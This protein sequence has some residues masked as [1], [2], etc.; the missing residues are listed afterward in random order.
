ME[1]GEAIRRRREELKLSQEYV[2]ERLGV[3]RQA[4]SKWET[5]QSEPTAGNL[6]QLAEVLEIGLS[7]LVDPYGSGREA[8]APE[9]EPPRKK[10]NLI[11]R[12]NLI[13]IA[14]ISQAAA[15]FS[16][17]SA[18]YQ[19]RHPDCPDKGLYRGAL[20]F[21]LLWLLLSSVWMAANH[22]WEP[23]PDRRRKNTRIELGYCCAQLLAGL[24]T[25]RFGMGLVGAAL[26]IALCLVYIL[27]VNP[28]FMSRRL[29]R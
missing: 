13:R 22:R 3:S 8:A 20:L 7:Q 19:L 4:V 17:T 12:A 29:T 15:L 21:D 2:A 14:I 16:C 11:L 27:Y 26:V 9:G 5:G 1:L 6:V 25:V 18:I 28:R 23:D 10:P 24:L